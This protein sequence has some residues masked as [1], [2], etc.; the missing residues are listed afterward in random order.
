M[1]HLDTC[2]SSAKVTHDAPS[3]KVDLIYYEK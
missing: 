3:S 1:E 2:D